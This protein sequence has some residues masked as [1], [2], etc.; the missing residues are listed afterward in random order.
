VKEKI[1]LGRWARPLMYTLRAMRRL[2][3]TPLDVFGVAKVRR[4]ERAM[5][6]EYI[7]AIRMLLD[8]LDD[9]NLAE[10]VAIA[11]LPDRVRGYERLK[12]E[13]ATAYRAEL[14]RRV[15]AFTAKTVAGAAG[16]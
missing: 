10:A 16:R 5:V 15:Q 11:S 4:I 3:G 12:L 2:R 1:G 9:S 13:R 7:D 14:E 8:H 6:P